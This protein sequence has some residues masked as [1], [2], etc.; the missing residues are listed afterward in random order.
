MKIILIVSLLCLSF[1]SSDIPEKFRCIVNPKERE[2]C[3]FVGIDRKKCEE[4]GC[5][6]RKSV[7]GTPWCFYGRKEEEKKERK[8][9]KE[10]EKEAEKEEKNEREFRPLNETEEIEKLKKF[11]DEEEEEKPKFQFR[12]FNKTEEEKEK[13]RKK[14]KTK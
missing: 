3:G 6:Y 13:E 12:P 5:C 1:I 8:E 9:D 4:K 11:L 14:G 10:D 7:D 2:D